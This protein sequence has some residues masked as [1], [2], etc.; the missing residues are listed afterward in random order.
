MSLIL[1]TVKFYNSADQLQLRVKKVADWVKCSIIH[2][3]ISQNSRAYKMKNT[4]WNKKHMTSKS[5]SVHH[6]SNKACDLILISVCVR[7]FLNLKLCQ[8]WSDWFSYACAWAFTHSQWLLWRCQ[9]DDSQICRS[10]IQKIS[11]LI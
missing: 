1:Y 3:K 7:H 11:L 8:H 4:W 2:S 6:V 10:Y 5:H 9:L